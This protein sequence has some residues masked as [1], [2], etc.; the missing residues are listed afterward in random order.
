MRFY[1]EYIT[2][3]IDK[4]HERLHNGEILI[5][6]LMIPIVIVGIIVEGTLLA[7]LYIRFHLRKL[8][9]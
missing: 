6:T 5:P 9:R 1:D 3:N 7:T 4:S 2:A 8:R